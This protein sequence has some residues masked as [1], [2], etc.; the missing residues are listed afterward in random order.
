LRGTGPAT[1][2]TVRRTN[3][4]PTMFRS[5]LGTASATHRCGSL[6]KLEHLEF[7]GIE[8]FKSFQSLFRYPND[9]P[10]HSVYV[11][12]IRIQIDERRAIADS[13]NPISFPDKAGPISRVVM[14]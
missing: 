4:S 10:A 9:C 5:L 8:A 2:W 7:G 13:I 6:S 11:R 12:V 3:S 1:K 14:E